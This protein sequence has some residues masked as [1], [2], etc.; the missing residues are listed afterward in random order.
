MTKHEI[1]TNIAGAQDEA[2]DREA[3][4]TLR[5]LMNTEEDDSEVEASE[6]E[7]SEEESSVEK[8]PA[9]KK[10]KQEDEKANE[11]EENSAEERKSKRKRIG[12]AIE[13]VFTGD[14]L[15][16]K[17]A[18]RIYNYLMLLG[19]IF[20]ISIFTMFNAFQKDREYTQLQERVDLLA[21]KATRT[22]EART[23]ES[24]HSEI[25]K[26]LKERGIELEDPTNAPIVLK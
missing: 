6:E 2:I 18:N 26:K 14:I 20:L 10:K 4:K 1:D 9:D 5:Q 24:S 13:S 7:P 11:E 17:E 12:A 23:K 8:A 19:V 21:E 15:L 3:V 25:V 16:A 22:L